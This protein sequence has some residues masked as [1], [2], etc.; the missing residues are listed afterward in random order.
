[1]K[2]LEKKSLL[3]CMG[4]KCDT[5]VGNDILVVDPPYQKK[6]IG[7]RVIEKLEDYAK[8]NKIKKLHLHAMKSAIPFYIKKGYIKS[9]GF[10]KEDNLM[11][12]KI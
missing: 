7:T 5:V 9:K 12:K 3:T 6:G 4:F 8:K 11:E 2:V 10:L 1:M